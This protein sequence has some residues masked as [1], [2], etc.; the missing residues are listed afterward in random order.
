M[1]K[2]FVQMV[3]EK[4]DLAQYKNKCNAFWHMLNQFKKCKTTKKTRKI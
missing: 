2:Q 1:T 4:A 3:Y